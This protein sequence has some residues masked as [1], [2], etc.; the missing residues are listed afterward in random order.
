MTFNNSARDA[1]R[2]EE[3]ENK[4]PKYASEEKLTSAL[5]QIS[6]LRRR[7]ERGPSVKVMMMIAFSISNSSLVPNPCLGH[8]ASVVFDIGDCTHKRRYEVSYHSMVKILQQNTCIDNSTFLTSCMRARIEQD[9]SN[10]PAYSTWTVDS[11]FILQLNES[12]TFLGKYL[13][14]PSVPWWNKRRETMAIAG[15]IPIA[16]WLTW[17]KQRSDVGCILCKRAREQ[18]DASTENLLEKTYGHINSAFCDGTATI[19]TAAHHIIWRH[20]YASLAECKLHKHQRVS[21]S[22]SHLIKRVVVM[23]KSVLLG[24]NSGVY[25]LKIFDGILNIHVCLKIY[26]LSIYKSKYLSIYLQTY[27][28]N[29]L[30]SSKLPYFCQTWIYSEKKSDLPRW[31]II[32]IL[33]AKK[34][35]VGMYTGQDGYD[36]VP[37]WC[38]QTLS[39][40]RYHI[41]MSNIF[42]V[43]R[44][45]NQTK[46]RLLDCLKS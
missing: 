41:F 3:A 6:T 16:I 2:R 39:G 4:V 30:K 18:H 9:N 8:N 25:L 22:L 36:C 29:L 19:V 31:Y 20:L 1:I 46:I 7:C 33:L 13:N 17:I 5:R 11:G 44:T 10:H 40:W 24:A 26:F 43:N 27:F 12:R 28:Q 38:T 32:V 21:S 42:H 23:Y 45:V 14:D 35:K 15:I 34:D 37:C